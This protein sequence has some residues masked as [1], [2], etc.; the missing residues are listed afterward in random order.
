MIWINIERR[1]N[2]DISDRLVVGWFERRFTTKNSAK[3]QTF[4]LLKRWW[5]LWNTGLWREDQTITTGL[6]LIFSVFLQILSGVSSCS[7]LQYILILK[8]R[9]L[10]LM[11]SWPRLSKLETQSNDCFWLAISQTNQTQGHNKQQMYILPVAI[12]LGKNICLCVAHF[13]F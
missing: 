5:K 12:Y 1:K 2:F 7:P 11:A 8:W 6:H 13:R 4:W 9:Q 3:F 10:I